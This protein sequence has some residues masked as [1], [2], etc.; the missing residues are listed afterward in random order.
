[1]GRIAQA[2]RSHGLPDDYIEELES[3]FE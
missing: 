1:M 3:W 2:A